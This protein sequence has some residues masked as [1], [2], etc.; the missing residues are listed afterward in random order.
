MSSGITLSL[1]LRVS[2]VMVRVLPQQDFSHHTNVQ[3]EIGVSTYPGFTSIEYF[4]L[5]VPAFTLHQVFEKGLLTSGSLF[6]SQ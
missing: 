3:C 4:V 1:C 5:L 6:M 2:I